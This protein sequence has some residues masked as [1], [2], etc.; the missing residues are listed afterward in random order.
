RAWISL[1][2][3]R[4]LGRRLAPPSRRADAGRNP[5]ESHR[6][7]IRVVSRLGPQSTFG[8]ARGRSRPAH[9]RGFRCLGAFAVIAVLTLVASACTVAGEVA[10]GGAGPE[11]GGTLPSTFRARLRNEA[12]KARVLIGAGATNPTY[13]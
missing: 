3:S 4:V 8:S 10:T 2:Q 5:L 7:T 6:S 11:G 13:L 12:A 9:G 1:T